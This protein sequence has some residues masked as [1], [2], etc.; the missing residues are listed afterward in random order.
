MNF[1]KKWS[2]KKP[3]NGNFLE[4][5]ENNDIIEKE[6][7]NF[8]ETKKGKTLRISENEGAILKNNK[9]YICDKK[10]IIKEYDFNLPVTSDGYIYCTEIT[11]ELKNNDRFYIHATNPFIMD[12]ILKKLVGVKK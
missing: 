8:I 11:G 9:T 6:K 10:G 1:E 12:H 7:L 4:L 3:E 2:I 5:Q